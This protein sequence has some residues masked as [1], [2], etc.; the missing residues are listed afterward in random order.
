MM[1][2]VDT[3][4]ISIAAKAKTMQDESAS[5]W[6]LQEAASLRFSEATLLEIEAGISKLREQGARQRAAAY[7]SWF[8]AILAEF[9]DRF[10][11]LDRRVLSKA[12]SLRGV[13][14]A[15]GFQASE[16]DCCIAA[17]ALLNDWPV[18]TFN[19]RHFEHLG[20][21]VILPPG[22]RTGP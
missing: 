19:A 10:L 1:L 21:P 3:N 5:A 8:D 14:F 18:A 16:M 17:T 20:V 11:P 12:G 9:S 22:N 2:L 7:R 6:L 4:V 13:A 15:K